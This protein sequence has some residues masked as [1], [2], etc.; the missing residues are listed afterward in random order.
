V[1]AG[2]RRYY[3]D[4]PAGQMHFTETGE[5]PA[6]VLLHWVPFSGRMYDHELAALAARGHRAI[7]IDLIGFGR[8]DHVSPR[9]GFAEHA[10]V[11]GEALSGIGL[12]SCALLG[13]HYSTP[14]ACELALAQQPVRISALLIDGAAHLLPAEAGRAIAA[15]LGRLAGPGW[16]EDASHRTFLWDQAE[17]TLAIFDPAFVTSSANIHL[18]Y[19]L[20][21][22][23]LSTG[24]PEEFGGFEPYD[25]A[26]KLGLLEIPVGMIS[27]ETDP[28]LPAYAPTLAAVRRPI[29][30][31]MP[32][33]HPLHDP[34]RA[35]T[36]ANEIADL[37][38]RCTVTGKGE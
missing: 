4:T 35:G 5:G 8:S 36:Y 15:K 2:L 22:D 24:M 14:V 33:G 7:A 30:R 1:V 3:V 34:A 21:L 18:V 13:A 27:A 9:L 28:L 37:L 26:G 6:V 10:Q 17:R 25:T 23:Y 29:G 12:E 38:E 31:V 16:H 11:L 32:G 20:I 19:R